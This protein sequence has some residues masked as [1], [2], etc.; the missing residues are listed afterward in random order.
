MDYSLYYS[1]EGFFRGR[2][3]IT[4]YPPG[5]KLPPPAARHGHVVDKFLAVALETLDRLVREAGVLAH[6]A[7]HALVAVLDR[8]GDKALVLERTDVGADLPL[9]DVEKPGKVSVGRE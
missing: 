6:R 8:D 5:R 9:P 1:V 3:T 7:D 4:S 2:R